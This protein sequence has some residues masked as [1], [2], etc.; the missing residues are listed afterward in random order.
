MDYMASK[1]STIVAESIQSVW[2]SAGKRKLLN[3][4]SFARERD[5]LLY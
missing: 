3:S 4:V 1:T 2:H 5:L